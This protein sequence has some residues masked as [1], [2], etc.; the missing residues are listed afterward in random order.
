[1]EKERPFHKWT[2]HETN[3]FCEILADL[4]NN[5]M[6]TLKRGTLKRH[7][8]VKYLIPLLLN[9]KKIFS[10]KKKNLK[11]LKQKRK[12]PNCWSKSKRFLEETCNMES[13]V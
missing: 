10:S 8:V 3:L 4:V 13:K 7:S 12:K 1:M 11:T 2:F 5:F 9:L 6:E